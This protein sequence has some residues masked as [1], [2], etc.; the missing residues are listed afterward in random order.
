MAR[1]RQFACPPGHCH[2]SRASVAVSREQE[3][4]SRWQ[5][6][7]FQRRLSSRETPAVRARSLDDRWLE[8]NDPAEPVELLSVRLERC[9]CLRVSVRLV[10]IHGH[11]V[12][13]SEGAQARRGCR[14]RLRV[15]PL[16]QERGAPQPQ[17][18]VRAPHRRGGLHGNSKTIDRMGCCEAWVGHSA[19]EKKIAST[20]PFADAS[21]E[22]LSLSCVRLPRAARWLTSSSST[23]RG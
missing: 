17:R 22:N 3:S 23:A 18:V 14:R 12:P 19:S 7:T 8:K 5:T 2:S 20:V 21:V 10:R 16:P 4:A 1:L 11:F 15:G 13:S 9:I 6:G